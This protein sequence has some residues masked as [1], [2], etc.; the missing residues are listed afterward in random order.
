MLLFLANEE[1][2]TKELNNTVQKLSAEK[3]RSFRNF[4]QL[5]LAKNDTDGDHTINME[6]VC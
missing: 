5:T 4:T 2:L 6:E 1:S 3:L